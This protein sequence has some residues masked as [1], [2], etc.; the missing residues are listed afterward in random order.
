LKY[1]EG[2]SMKQL[3]FFIG[4]KN[5]IPHAMLLCKS[6]E[7][8][9]DQREEYQ[10]YAV[11][12][13]HLMLEIDIPG[14]KQITFDM[15]MEYASIPYVDKMFAAAA[16]EAICEEEYIWMEVDSYF[17]KPLEYR[18][19]TEIYVNSVDK[20]NI[21]DVFGDERSEIWLQLFQYFG[22]PDIYPFM[23]TRVTKERIYP[24][25]NVNMVL[26]NQNRALFKTVKEAICILLSYDK[27]QKLIQTSELN[28]TYLHQAVFTCAVLKLYNKSVKPLPYAVN[29]PLYL[30]ENTPTP[31]PFA[32][33]ISIRYHDYFEHH[34]A[35]SMWREIF[36]PVKKDLKV[37]WYY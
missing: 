25:Y 35:P 2:Q 3:G 29:Y 16:F 12:P 1:R 4:H 6:L 7:E 21:G 30:H 33:I 17:F 13:K 11:T 34:N 36:D 14:V 19:S 32:D 27:I 5:Y 28:K 10:I 18:K 37:T 15:P 24:Y 26:I 20:R 23:I 9:A 8:N 31:V 22:I